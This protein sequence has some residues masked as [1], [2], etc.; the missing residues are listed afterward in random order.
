MLPVRE[1]SEVVV[2]YP[3]PWGFVATPPA[4]SRL[5][6]R[7]DVR[8]VAEDAQALASQRTRGDV[9]DGWQELTGAEVPWEFH[10]NVDN[11]LYIYIYAC[12]D[13]QQKKGKKEKQITIYVYIIYIYIL[14]NIYTYICITSQFQTDPNRK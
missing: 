13:N 2:I 9:E 6:R 1:N 8:V 5:R 3:D 4:W 11:D 14:I 12:K 10:V 7:H